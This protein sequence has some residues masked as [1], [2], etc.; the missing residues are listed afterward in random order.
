MQWQRHVQ[1]RAVL[2]CCVDVLWSGRLRRPD[3]CAKGGGWHAAP[4]GVAQSLAQLPGCSALVRQAL[5]VTGLR[6]AGQPMCCQAPPLPGILSSS[7]WAQLS[8]GPCQLSRSGQGLTWLAGWT[9]E[10]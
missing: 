1:A 3:S 10:F 9:F 4:C 8:Y 6:A 2:V 7:S 5:L